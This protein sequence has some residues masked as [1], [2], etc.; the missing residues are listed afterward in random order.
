MLVV[1]CVRHPNATSVILR[2]FAPVDICLLSADETAQ[3]VRGPA[4]QTRG[5]RHQAVIPDGVELGLFSE[6]LGGLKWL[7]ARTYAPLR[8]W[9]YAIL[10]STH[11][12]TAGSRNYHPKGMEPVYEKIHYA[13][14]QS[15]SYD[16]VSGQIGRDENM[17]IVEGSEAQIAQ[18]LRTESSRRR[19]VTM[20]DIVDLTTS[21]QTCASCTVH[22]GEGP[23]ITKDFPAWTAIGAAPRRRPGV[24]IEIKA[25]AALV[26]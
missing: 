23:P 18:H 3:R 25:V 13:P 26:P 24:V 20:A 15:G 14:S 9:R 8:N 22:A 17:R 11:G 7:G 10:S 6:I 2:T 4:E 19:R 12:E 1:A 21:T 5:R 16:H